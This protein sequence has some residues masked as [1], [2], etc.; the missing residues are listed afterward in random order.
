MEKSLLLFHAFWYC[1]ARFYRTVPP[2]LQRIKRLPCPAKWFTVNLSGEPY[3]AQLGVRPVV[4]SIF[5]A[6]IDLTGALVYKNQGVATDDDAYTAA[7]L[8]GT[9]SAELVS[10]RP[11]W[12]NT[13]RTVSG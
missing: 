10:A 13:A 2:W 9:S 11:S 7:S 1:A 8:R 3:N 5:V 6:Q 12:Y 4:I